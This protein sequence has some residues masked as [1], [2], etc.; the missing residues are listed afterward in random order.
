[1]SIIDVFIENPLYFTFVSLLVGL[2]V[3][4]F[5]NVVIYRL[6]IMMMNGWRQEAK[7]ILEI[8]EDTTEQ[9]T[10]FNLLLPA[11]RCPNCGHKISAL[12][13]IPIISYL[14]LKGQCRECH[15]PISKR[16]PLVELVTG[17]LTAWLA[18]YFGATAQ[19]LLLILLTWGLIAM[20]MI[21]IDHQLLPDSLVLPLLWI[22]LL[23]NLYGLLPH[24]TIESAILGAVIGY[25]ILWTVNAIFKL[26]RGYDGMG[27]GDFKLL[28][29]F[30]AW[31]GYQILPVV[32]LF[33]AFAGAVIGIISVVL[34]KG[35]NKFPFGP[36]LAI[37]GWIALIWG[38]DIVTGYLRFSGI[39]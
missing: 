39:Q 8:T 27:N 11:S 20:S 7:E 2:L 21:D 32:I 36:Y 26:I 28:A 16:Y 5:L 22:G 15:N 12:E 17:L 23:A 31:G 13:N 18:W 30:G 33:S 37:A 29:L 24:L 19:A 25:M 34:F 14:C 1:M 9:K 10:T 4:S 3:G 6:P 38:Q 35:K